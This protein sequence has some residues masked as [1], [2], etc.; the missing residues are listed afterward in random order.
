MNAIHFYRIERWFYG[1]VPFMASIIHHIIFLLF[2][3]HIPGSCLIGKGTRFAYGA[4]G[5]VLHADCKIGKNCIIGTNV[6]IGGRGRKGVPVI[7][8]NVY[9]A[10]GA[11]VLGPITIG[12][13]VVIGANAVVINDVPANVVVAGIP[14][15]IIKTKNIG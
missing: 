8:D 2:N 1:K 11:K 14:A 3:S 13:N 10:T 15:K 5:I 12:D 7:G 9:I 4:I 6:T